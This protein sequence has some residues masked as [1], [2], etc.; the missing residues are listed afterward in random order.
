MVSESRKALVAEVDSFLADPK[1]LQG[2]HP[3]WRESSR[4]GEL[5]AVWN[6]ED[7]L[8]IS[9]AH[10][11]FRLVPVDW[12]HPS[13]SVIFRAQKVWRVDMAPQIKCKPNPLFARRLG[14]PAE[15]CGSH[16]HTWFDNRDHIL[17]Q[18]VWD[19]PARRPI[20]PQIRRIP[21]ALADLADTINL[22]LA[23][24][25]RDFDRPAQGELFE[26]GEA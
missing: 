1:C 19:I 6:I 9:N 5:E 4:K 22:T 17:N 24:E 14:L 16:A 26:R 8:G 11:R 10:L 20:A 12:G 21:Q 2:G 3:E 13:I 15:V 18:D 23:A 7:S 25:Q